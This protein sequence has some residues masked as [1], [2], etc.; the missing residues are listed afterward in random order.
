MNKDEV[1]SQVSDI[2]R[3]VL[4]QPEINITLATTADDIDEWDSFNHINIM[5]AVEAH[6]RIKINTAEVEELKNVGELVD[7]V[8][9]KQ[10]LRK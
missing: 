6:F 1:L 5:V 7:L 2:I 10:S 8:L 9:H 4:D 3:D